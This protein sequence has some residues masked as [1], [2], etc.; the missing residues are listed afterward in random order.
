MT[1][2]VIAEVPESCGRDLSIER[3]ILGSDVEIV[4]YSYDGSE[5]DL[6]SACEDADIVFTEYAPLTRNVL[7]R[8]PKCR[9]ISFSA[10]G[11][12][13]VDLQAAKDVNISVCAVDEYCTNEVADHVLLLILALCRRLPEYHEQVQQEKLWQGESLT[14]LVRMSSLTL[15]IVGFGRIGQAVARRAHGFGMTIIAH[16]PHPDTGRSADDDVEFCDLKALF[17]KA[18]IISLNCGLTANNRSLLDATAFRQM[19]R[20]PIL[21]N[22][23]RGGLID[24]AALLEA[25]DTGQISAAGL[26]V[27]DDNSP[28]LRVTKLIG[29]SNVLLTPHI[30]YYSD[31]SLLE[32][33]SISASNIRHCLDGK[34]EK[35]RRY[36]Y[37][38]AD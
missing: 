22:C 10:T 35:V 9:L 2:V 27:L 24:E 37:H 32:C 8:M 5:E 6:I 26:D 11:Y 31:T 1:R 20:R 13:S 30:A 12:D 15:G 14:G 3:S 38:A 21:I 7:E 17:A 23:A 19:A 18:D 25:L 28:D 33:R 36:I 29:R 4:R 16:D 34:H